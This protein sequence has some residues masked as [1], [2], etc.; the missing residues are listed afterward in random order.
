MRLL[1][2]AFCFCLSK[3]MRHIHKCLHG[4]TNARASLPIHTTQFVRGRS[5]VFS[6]DSSSDERGSS[7]LSPTSSNLITSFSNFK[8]WN[9]HRRKNSMGLIFSISRSFVAS[10]I[11]SSRSFSKK[12]KTEISTQIIRYSSFHSSNLQNIVASSHH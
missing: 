2:I 7:S 11:R 6:F 12:K 5:A 1:L 4:I 10:S 3:Q 8:P 9:V